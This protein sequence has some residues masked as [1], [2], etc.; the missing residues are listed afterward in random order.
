MIPRQTVRRLTGGLR[1]STPAA[2]GLLADRG[3][4]SD[5]V[6]KQVREQLFLC[7]ETAESSEYTIGTSTNCAIW[8]RMPSC[9]SS[10]GTA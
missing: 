7:A 2:S 9:I 6:V 5:A 1:Q 8:L 3:C 10:D 4:D